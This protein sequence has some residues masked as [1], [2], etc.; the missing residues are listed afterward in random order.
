MPYGIASSPER[1]SFCGENAVSRC[2]PSG[3]NVSAWAAVA[4]Q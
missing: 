1:G 3:E 2:G 4:Q